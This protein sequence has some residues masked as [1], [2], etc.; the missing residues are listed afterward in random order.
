MLH[1]RFNTAFRCATNAMNIFFSGVTVGFHFSCF[2]CLCSAVSQG[3]RVRNQSGGTNSNTSTVTSSPDTEP[4]VAPSAVRNPHNSWNN[5]CTQTQQQQQILR[6]K[7]RTNKK[8]VFSSCS[9]VVF[10][11][12]LLQAYY[13]RRQ[14]MLQQNI[15]MLSIDT[16]ELVITFLIYPFLLAAILL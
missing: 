9:S 6:T 11:V 8:R 2:V 13:Y 1:K 15:I 7:N 16:V 3:N 10:F 5:I 12:L 14:Q 4:K